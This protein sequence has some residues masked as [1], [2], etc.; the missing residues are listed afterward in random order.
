MTNVIK[1]GGLVALETYTVVVRL[2]DG[3]LLVTAPQ[4]VQLDDAERALRLFCTAEVVASKIEAEWSGFPETSFS[5]VAEAAAELR[6]AIAAWRRAAAA[7]AGMHLLEQ[8][9]VPS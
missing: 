7:A 5:R 4:G 6:E 2:P 1:A 9:K 3:R 8:Q